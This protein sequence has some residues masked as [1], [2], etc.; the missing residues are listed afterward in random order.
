ME[1]ATPPNRRTARRFR[2]HHTPDHH[3]LGRSASRRLRGRR[4]VYAQAPPH[5]ETGLHCTICV[6]STGARVN[7]RGRTNGSHAG[8]Y[9]FLRAAPTDTAFVTHCNARSFTAQS[10]LS[11]PATRKAGTSASLFSGACS[12]P[13]VSHLH[14]WPFAISALIRKNTSRTAS[15]AITRIARLRNDEPD[16]S[17]KPLSHTGRIGIVKA[18]S[19]WHHQFGQCRSV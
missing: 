7:I 8:M 12:C 16:R 17:R 9:V 15:P 1:L 6:H 13:H 10:P 2:S 5:P 11:P 3:K 14:V 4:N 18:R 19:H